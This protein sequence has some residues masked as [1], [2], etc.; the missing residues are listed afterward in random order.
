[1]AKSLS[2]KH[3]IKLASLYLGTGNLEQSL[4]AAIHDN[5]KENESLTVDILLDFTR[6]NR[7]I[8][9][10]KTKILPLMQQSTKCA[11]SL[12]HTPSLRGI[13]K[14]LT[15]PPWN[16][17]LGLQHMKIYLFDDTVILSGANLSNDYFTNRQDRYIMIEDKNLADFY[18]KF[19]SKVQEFSLKVDSTGREMLHEKWKLSPYDSDLQEFT[20]AARASV[21][22]FFNETIKEQSQRNQKELDADTW[23]F[24][25]IEMGQIGIHHDSL[26]VNR[27]LSSSVHG[28]KINLAT[29]YFNLTDSYMKTLTYDC[30]ADCNILVAHPNVS[31]FLFKTKG[32]IRPRFPDK[33][34]EASKIF[35]EIG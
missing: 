28:S 23:I 16:E 27:L 5:L 24:P 4:V 29:G 20:K 32:P 18:S 15:P 1:M 25:T 7:G 34:P 17:L 11:L 10:S 19:I 13:T 6:G 8:E 12:Y 26:V 33:F 2:A 22:N 35:P 30:I 14:K 9:N 21:N 31:F 3:R